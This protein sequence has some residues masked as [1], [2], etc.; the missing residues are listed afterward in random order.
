MQ[1]GFLKILL[2]RK[3]GKQGSSPEIPQTLPPLNLLISLHPA[4]QINVTRTIW[5]GLKTWKQETRKKDKWIGKIGREISDDKL[6]TINIFCWQME[7]N[8]R[9]GVRRRCPPPHL[10]QPERKYFRNMCFFGAE[11]TSWIQLR[12]HLMCVQ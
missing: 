11:S 8:V 2:S 5:W 4:P 1:K 3:E 6:Y 10:F 9:D 7:M 12:T